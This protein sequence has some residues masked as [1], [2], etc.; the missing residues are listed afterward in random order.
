ME[1]E[2]PLSLIEIE[3]RLDSVERSSVSR[4]LTLFKKKHLVHSFEDGSGSIKYEVCREQHHSVNDLHVHFRCINCGKT[5]CIND[6]AIP[7][8]NLPVG[9]EIHDINYVLSGRCPDCT[10]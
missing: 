2:T 10:T 9:Y 1:S 6:V 3:E 8:V 5:I 4:A 7:E